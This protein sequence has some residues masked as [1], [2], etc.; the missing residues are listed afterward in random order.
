MEA[1]AVQISQYQLENPERE[2]TMVQETL[3]K[4]QGV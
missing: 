2:G 1:E 3:M 4:Y